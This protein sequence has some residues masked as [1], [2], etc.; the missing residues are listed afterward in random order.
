[1][2]NKS[3]QEERSEIAV[4]LSGYLA[5]IQNWVTRI[6][7]N[8]DHDVDKNKILSILDGW[9]AHIQVEKEKI[10]KMKNTPANNKKESK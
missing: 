8:D 2:S 7:N 1:M 10:M 6:L 9:I 5:M 3:W 4:W